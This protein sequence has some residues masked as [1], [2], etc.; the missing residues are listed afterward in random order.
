[1]IVNLFGALG[2]IANMLV[3]QQRSGKNLLI[4]KLISDFLWATHYFLLS[5]HSAMAIAVIGIFREIVFYNQKKKWA[6]SKLWLLFFLI[7]SISSSILTWKSFFSVL[8][9]IASFI[10]V[11]SF[12]KKNPRL[13]RYLAFPISAAMLTY[14]ITCHS[15][16][17]ITN[18]IFVLIS[19]IAGIIRYSVLKND[20][21]SCIDE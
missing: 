8:P 14:D 1:M 16:M 3:Y 19:A 6:K 11:I 10:S 20:K 18:D 13:S 21:S 7:C 2:I 9:G 4:V 17:G 15:Y 5:A 12:W